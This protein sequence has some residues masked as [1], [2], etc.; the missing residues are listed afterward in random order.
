MKKYGILSLALVLTAALLAGCGCTNQNMAPTTTPTVLPT[1]EENWASTHA[2][3]E[4]TS[5]PTQASTPSENG[6][7]GTTDATIDH[8]NGPLEDNTTTA[9]GNTVEGR[10]RQGTGG[11]FG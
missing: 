3:T 7:A 2:T 4:A 10:T 6:A 8:G 5:A 11:N 9:T 1:N